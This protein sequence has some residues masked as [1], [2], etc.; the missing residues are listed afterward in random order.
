M[1]YCF[2]KKS[3]AQS[4]T[5]VID[6][7]IRSH[8]N[9]YRKTGEPFHMHPLRMH[10]SYTQ[11]GGTDSLIRQAILL[12]DTVEDTSITLEDIENLF[13]E[14]VARIVDAITCYDQMGNKLTKYEA[15][16]KFIEYSK[17]DYRCLIV[18]L[19]D[20]IDNLETIHGLSPKKQIIF[21]NEKRYVYLPVFIAMMDVIPYKYRA[22]YVRKVE[23]MR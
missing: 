12:H 8:T 18:K 6:F 4:D 15:F 11:M 1:V 21:K 5:M 16:Q 9:Q 3:V 13:G 17:L 7:M 2:Q 23:E 20:C 19:F 22:V 14:P 10:E